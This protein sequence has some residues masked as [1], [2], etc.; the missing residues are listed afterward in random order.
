M[1]KQEVKI[2]WLIIVALV[3]IG[4]GAE[5]KTHLFSRAI[6]SIV[7]DNRLHGVNCKDLPELAEVERIVAENQ[8]MVE[9]ILN[10]NPGHIFFYIGSSCPEKGEIVIYYASHKDRKRIEELIGKTFFGVPWTGINQ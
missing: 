7:W 4:V 5:L 9:E 8:D 2:V 3:I 6:I 1:K 10:I